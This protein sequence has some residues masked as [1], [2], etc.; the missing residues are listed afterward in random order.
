M[1]ERTEEDHKKRQS[2]NPVSTPRKKCANAQIRC[3]SVTHLTTTIVV[4]AAAAAALVVVAVLVVVVV[5]VVEVVV[6][7]V[8]FKIGSWLAFRTRQVRFPTSLQAMTVSNADGVVT[9]P[10][11]PQSKRRD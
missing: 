4:A 3:Y 9:V 5:V 2:L 8:F 11:V 6:V 7:V 10:P 1:P